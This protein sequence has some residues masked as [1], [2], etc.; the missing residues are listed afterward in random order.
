MSSV[1]EIDTGDFDTLP[2]IDRLDRV[3]VVGATLVRRACCFTSKEPLL[4]RSSEDP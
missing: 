1:S 2:G 4:C 3:E